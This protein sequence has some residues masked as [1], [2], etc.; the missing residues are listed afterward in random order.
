MWAVARLGSGH[1]RQP[2][3][4]GFMAS[5]RLRNMVELEID[6][7]PVKVEP[8]TPL[9]TACLEAGVEI[10]RFC[11]HER[12]AIAGNCRMCL[13]ENEKAPKPLASCAVPAAPGMKIHTNTPGVKKA[14]EGVMEFLLANHPLDCPICD[15]AG[16]CDLQDQSM[17]YGSDR[18]RMWE[19]QQFAHT[20]TK[21]AVEDKNFG[22]LVKTTMTRCIHC[23][24]CVRF[25]N[26]VAGF[27]GLGSS[28]RGNDMQIGMYVDRM[29]DSE[30]SGNIVD[31]CPVGALTSRPYAFTARP[32]EL[33]HTESI[34]VHDAL[35][36]NIRVD[37]RGLEVMR[38][39]P[40]LH[41]DVNEEWLA[42]KSRAATDGLKVQRLGS[43]MIREGS[44]FRAVPW[45]EALE[46]IRSR[47]SGIEGSKMTAVAGQ[48]ADV[49]SMVAV[50]DL[51]H[52]LG[53]N[54][55]V[56]ESMPKGGAHVGDLRGT[57]V[58]NT[59]I[60]AME[61]AD[62]V[63]LVGSN[64]RH[65][66]PL[67]QT[68]LRKAW[69]FNGSQVGVVGQA[70]DLTVEYDHLGTSLK[71]VK[72]LKG[73][74]GAAFAGAKKPAVIFGADVFRNASHESVMALMRSL[75]DKYPNLVQDE[76]N[77]LNVL[78]QHASAVGA[79]DVGFVG[80][81][82]IS[83]KAMD[84]VYLL[85][86]DDFDFKIPESSFVIYQGH[87]GERGAEVA[88]V[89]L[90]GAAYTEKEATY[91]NAEGR[92]QRTSVA[93]SPPG[94][95]RPDWAVVRALAE[96]LGHPLAYDS[97]PELRDRLEQIAP[98]LNRIDVVEPNS[99]AVTK[100][101][102]SAAVAGALPTKPLQSSIHDYYQ[103]NVIAR[104]SSTMAK[105][106]KTLSKK[107]ESQRATM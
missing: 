79:L 34:D 17:V 62:A 66:A 101:G 44:S 54:N 68:R 81:T 43:P 83:P 53:S 49:E 40:R 78:Q 32:W 63:V 71:D 91:V 8:N 106:S 10:P 98:H 12:L 86:A 20:H 14:R 6:G 33:R 25:A 69:L 77:G 45:E 87:H 74:F 21:R 36:S 28:G 89:I 13:V 38:V 18:S 2:L 27:D 29:M 97:L 80:Q 48:L 50:K 5:P 3:R 4:R 41:E 94:D 99:A 85:N 46:T 107:N 105:C 103:T 23:T 93:V 9:I 67:L 15:Q 59:G 95:A 22:P 51:F 76:W 16:E 104:A 1:L 102:L 88:D 82:E 24:R 26:E 100:A 84:V 37:C 42:D 70:H 92:P 73:E 61:E 64:I 39:L 56:L 55:F 58:L 65:E 47:I 96:V 19:A 60:A 31:L 90:P 52:A 35:G 11:Y 72:D 7:I 57:Y 75:T 30:L